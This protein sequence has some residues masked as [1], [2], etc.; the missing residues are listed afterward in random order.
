MTGLNL[1]SQLTVQTTKYVW[2]YQVGKHWIVEDG[3]YNLISQQ[4]QLEA[5]TYVVQINFPVNA[6]HQQI[7]SSV[8][9]NDCEHKLETCKGFWINDNT[10]QMTM[11]QGQPHLVAFKIF[12]AFLSLLALLSLPK[13]PPRS[14]YLILKTPLT[15]AGIH[16]KFLRLWNWKSGLWVCRI[17]NDWF[18]VNLVGA[19]CE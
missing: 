13:A 8:T 15:A 5:Y 10:P 18:I 16:P 19:S 9:S 3:N 7:Y 2:K 4:L 11:G 1:Y 14:K 17:K 12:A 6:Q